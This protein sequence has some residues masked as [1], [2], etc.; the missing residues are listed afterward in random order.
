MNRESIEIKE[1]YE[2][3]KFK[4]IYILKNKIILNKK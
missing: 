2:K 4:S 1:F 3:N